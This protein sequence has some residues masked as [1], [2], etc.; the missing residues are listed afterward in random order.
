[1]REAQASAIPAPEAVRVAMWSGPRNISTALLRAWGSRPDTFVCDEPLYSHYLAN[2]A[3]GAD[4]PARDEIIRRHERDW[5]KVATWLTGPVPGGR[6]IFYQKHMAHH[7]LPGIERGWLRCLTHAFLIRAPREMLLSLSKVLP[8]PNLDDTGLPQQVELFEWTRAR[9]GVAPPVL[10]ARDV[11]EHPRELLTLLCGRLGVPF[12][13]AMLRWEPGPRP[14]DG[15]WGPHWYGAAYESTGFE[16]YRPREEPLPASLHGV[17]E[18]C[19]PLYE[20]LYAVRLR[21][22]DPPHAD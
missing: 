5:R 13:D 10:D 6:S 18:Q 11:L 16:T 4:H 12:H 7:L 22:T 14:S 17:L 21:A 2:S 8:D 15:V 9:T 1:M 20:R 3:A 19:L